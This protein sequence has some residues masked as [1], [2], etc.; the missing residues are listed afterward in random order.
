MAR[1]ADDERLAPHSGHEHSPRGLA[2][3]WFSEFFEAGDLVDYHRGTG[4]AQLAFPLAEPHEQLL[5]G[6]ADR[7]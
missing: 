6:D 5:A 7:D 3:S 2:W 4:L 1:R